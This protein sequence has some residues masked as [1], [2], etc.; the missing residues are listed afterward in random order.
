MAILAIFALR[1]YD[2][3]V[4]NPIL[5]LSS[6]RSS[7]L[8]SSEKLWKY[9][10]NSFCRLLSIV[11][12]LILRFLTSKRPPLLY[13]TIYSFIG[14]IYYILYIMYNIY[15]NIY[16]HIYIYTYIY[17]SLHLMCRFIVNFKFYDFLCRFMKKKKKNDFLLYYV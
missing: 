5:P 10:I 15:I 2:S 4:F 13:S 3:S 11:I 9:I 12:L 7:K 8:H 1:T 16:I 17:T 6:V 14:V